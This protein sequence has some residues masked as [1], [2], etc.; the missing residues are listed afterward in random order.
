MNIIEAYK[1]AKEGQTIHRKGWPDNTFHKLFKKDER[2]VIGLHHRDKPIVYISPDSFVANDW[3]VVKEKKEISVTIETF[4][5]W[6]T[7]DR[8]FKGTHIPE[9][10][11]IHISW[12]E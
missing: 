9:N 8:T 1:Q 7:C 12:E 3:E 5:T 2:Y 11:I 10:A 4:M 6:I